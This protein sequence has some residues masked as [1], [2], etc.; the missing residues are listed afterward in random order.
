MIDEAHV[1]GEIGEVVAGKAPGRMSS[2][3]ITLYKSLGVAT[4]D[5][6][7][8]KSLLDL[9][10]NRDEHGFSSCE[11]RAGLSERVSVMA[12]ARARLLV[13]VFSGSLE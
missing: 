11:R 12:T 2:L 5:L 9:A 8:A 10:V 6:S 1:L 4:Q 7:V 13:Q 3:D